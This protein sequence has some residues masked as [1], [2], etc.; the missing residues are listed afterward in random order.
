MGFPREPGATPQ[1]RDGKIRDLYPC[2]TTW[3]PPAGAVNYADETSRAAFG[4]NW[5]YITGYRDFHA[6]TAPVGSFPPNLH[7]IHDL[8][9]NVWE[10]CEDWWNNEQKYRVLRGGSW[11]NNGREN[12]FSSNRNNDTPTMVTTTTGFGT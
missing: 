2:G 9:G 5:T 12:L 3:P 6:T 10:W 8:G 1:Y 4:T 11:N 7:G